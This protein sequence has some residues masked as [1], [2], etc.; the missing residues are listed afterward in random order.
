[1]SY[2]LI[3]HCTRSNLHT[4]R[5]GVYRGEPLFIVAE[6]HTKLKITASKAVRDDLGT[7]EVPRVIVKS[8]NKARAKPVIGEAT[9]QFV[10]TED[11]QQA[12]LV[13][14]LET[15]STN[16]DIRAGRPP[17][18][19]CECDETLK[20]TKKHTCGKCGELV[21]CETRK[22]DWRGSW[23]CLF[24]QIRASTAPPRNMVAEILKTSLKD[25]FRND[26]QKLGLD[27][28][29]AEQQ[30]VYNEALDELSS[31]I[32]GTDEYLDVYRG[33]KSVRISEIAHLEGH[34]L[35]SPDLPSV[36]GIFSFYECNGKLR[37]HCANNVAVTSIALNY[38]KHMQHPA[39]LSHIS[40]FAKSEKTVADQI[41]VLNKVTN[42]ALI[43][44]KV[45][46]K[47]R[48]RT[49]RPFKRAEFQNDLNEWM[50]DRLAPSN[51]AVVFSTRRLAV[52]NRR[53]RRLT[54]KHTQ[55][56]LKVVREIEERFGV[57]LPR[58]ADGCPWFGLKD[59]MP[60]TWCW[61]ECWMLVCERLERLRRWCNRYWKSELY[62]GQRPRIG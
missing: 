6:E 43:R 56:L 35:Y 45:P 23:I 33:K 41:R 40:E 60:E 53:T 57:S 39:F 30:V 3:N 26:C 4:A 49:K 2:K 29:A 28:D 46:Y 8:P 18:N 54:A 51:K 13:L 14:G 55:R 42:T 22:Q 15:D 25:T 48:T 32:K 19:A 62:T 27:P 36:D 47:I 61:D 20:R 50:S 16:Q 17:L 5:I 7:E 58:S 34:S 52:G 11:I 12:L 24:C 1:V 9:A 21:L 44:L 59:A 38:L 37:Y 31:Y 10:E